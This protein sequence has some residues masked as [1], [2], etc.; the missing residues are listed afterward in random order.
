MKTHCG[1]NYCDNLTVVKEKQSES[2]KQKQPNQQKRQNQWSHAAC[3]T[4]T[5]RLK[6]HSCD[7]IKT[8]KYGLKQPF[9]VSVDTIEN[10][11]VKFL[12]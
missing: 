7:K 4:T 8:T 6:Q 5:Q 12:N 11:T 10:K 9:I 1:Q 2:M 3:E